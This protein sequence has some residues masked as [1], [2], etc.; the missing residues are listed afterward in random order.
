ME[1]MSQEQWRRLDVLRR[2]EA[3]G[4]TRAEA[5][6]VLGLSKRQVRRL[7]GAYVR[8]GAEAL[9]HGNTGREPANKVGADIR[10]QVLAL[11]EQKY[12]GFNDQHFTE[13]LVSEGV[14]VSRAT[15][16]RLL[17]EA[18]YRAVRRR[19]A[20]RHRR[21]RDRRPQAGM[22]MLWDG[23]L[24]EWMEDRGPA[25]CLIA[26]IDDATGEVLPGAHFA[27]RECTVSYLKTLLAIARAKGLPLSAY[28]DQHSSL[29]RN[30]AFWTL[31][32]ELR[33][34]RDPTQVGRALKALGVEIIYALSPQAKGRVERLW[35]TL[36]DRL[37]SE[38]RLAGAKTLQQANAVLM[39]HLPE[40]NRR[41][42]VPAADCT[43]AWRPVRSGLDLDR[44][45]SFHYVATV[46]NDNTVRI[47][48]QVI[49]IPPGPGGR[50]YPKAVVQACQLIDGSW[51]IYKRDKIIAT[52][53]STALTEVRALHQR[54]P[55]AAAER[56]RWKTAQH[57]WATS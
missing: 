46:L 21:R 11:F 24:H 6:R 4:L 35:G 17:R 39:R 12:D 57:L 19:R 27:E 54:R 15:V 23:S 10:R 13:K 36:Q 29:K 43:P 53:A 16:R 38:L 48:G 1:L 49:D 20:T 50:G 44:V 32:E 51:R 30:D 26:A 7:F 18:G 33:G 28:M 22:M 47:G 41:F 3:G 5:A 52:A 56:Q 2:I 25:L 45:C 9:V 42:A 14:K 31:E 40:H 55:S 34:E 37:V 8:K